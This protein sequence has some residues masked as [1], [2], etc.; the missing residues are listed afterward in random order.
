MNYIKQL[1][2]FYNTLDY[3]PISANAISVYLVL[4][5]IANKANWIDEF[6]VA[7]ITLLSK[8]KINMSAMQRAR[9][10]LVQKEYITYQKGKNQNECSRYTIIKLYKFEQAGE[11]ANEQADKQAGEQA[12]ELAPEHINKQN[13]TIQNKNIYGEFKHVLLTD[14]ELE[15]IKDYFWKDY[16]DRIRNLDE[17]LENNPKKHYENH[18]LTLR[19]WA[20]K[21][22]YVRPDKPKD[23]KEN[24]KELL[25]QGKLTEEEYNLIVEE[26]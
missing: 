23:E 15:K 16:K 20:R 19:K 6:T 18:Y 17:Y 1:N 4:F 3:K 10:E 26:V 9:N 25:K 24:A 2:E 22:N 21:E 7:N 5:C 12:D 13:N 14:E 11:Q 8:C